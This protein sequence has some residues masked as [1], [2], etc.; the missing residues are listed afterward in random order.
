MPQSAPK[1]ARPPRAAIATQER[2]IFALDVP[3]ASSARKLVGQL[4][5]A[6]RFYK[7]GLE[8]FMSGDYFELVDWLA[9]QGKKIFADLKFFDIPATVA[10]AV[11]GLRGRGVTFTTVHGYPSIM[12]A[13]AQAKGDVKILAVT[14]LTSLD[15]RDLDELGT[16]V[17]VEQLVVTRARGAL[18]SGCD[19]VICSGQEAALVRQVDPR[20]LIVTP[21]IRPAQNRAADD[22]KRVVTVE[23][24]FRDGVDHI[25]VGRPIRDAADPRVA[26]ENIQRTIATLFST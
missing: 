18:A 3:D 17:E 1:P 20:L 14:V 2:L 21:G 16:G 15:R 8:L 12:E 6:V 13:A 10:A 25:V 11:K 23:Q 9:A 26:A 7:L 22:Q 5:D 4:G 24:A 19:G